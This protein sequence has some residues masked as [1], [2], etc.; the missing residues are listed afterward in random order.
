[1][2]STKKIVNILIV[3]LALPL[4]IYAGPAFGL[5]HEEIFNW[6]ADEL[7]ITTEYPM[8]KIFIVPQEEL[9]RIF[10][11]ATEQ[12]LKQWT[13]IYGHEEAHKIRDR[14]L[15]EVLGLFDPKNKV[16]YV[17]DFME[18]CKQQ[19]I[20]AHEIT[21]YFQNLERGEIDPQS[22]DA[23]ATV[24][25][26]EMEASHIENTFMKTFSVTLGIH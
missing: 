23:A 25:A 21:H 10:S 19:S 24:T 6:V 4:M 3:V 22:Y 26:Y 12:S 7:E 15:K 8:P 16:I 17:G 18:P 1:M 2:R 11:K 13:K 9:Q 14:Y 20:I 5:S